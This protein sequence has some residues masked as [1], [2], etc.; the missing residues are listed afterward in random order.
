MTDSVL[1]ITIRIRR[2]SESALLLVQAEMDERVFANE[3]IVRRM[4]RRRGWRDGF[5]GAGA[6]E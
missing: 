6:G 5:R 4:R 3:T 1:S 2:R